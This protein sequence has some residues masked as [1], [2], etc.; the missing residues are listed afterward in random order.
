MRHHDLERTTSGTGDCVSRR[1][2]EARFHMRFVLHAL[3]VNRCSTVAIPL[4]RLN[5]NRS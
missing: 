4:S 5:R 1:V 3:E 2:E